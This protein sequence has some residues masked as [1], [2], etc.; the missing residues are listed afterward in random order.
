MNSGP[1]FP[2]LHTI[3]IK[4]GKASYRIPRSR[5]NH[6]FVQYSGLQLVPIEEAEG[7]AEYYDYEIVDDTITFSDDFLRLLDAD[8]EGEVVHVY[9]SN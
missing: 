8:S 2:L 5:Y 1:D 4:L 7:Y 6:Y 9:Y 3:T